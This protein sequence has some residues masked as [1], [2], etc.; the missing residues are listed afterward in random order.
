MEYIAPLPVVYQAP[1]PAVEYITPVPAVVQ[2]P[3]PAVEYIAPA[4]ALFLSPSSVVEFAAPAPALSVAPAPGVESLSHAPVLSRWL[5]PAVDHFSPA[6]A[7]SR[8]ARGRG[9]Q[10]SVSGQ[11]SASRR[12]HAL[13]L[14]SGWRRVEDVSGRVYYWH[15]HTSQTRWT[16]PGSDDDDEDEE[17]E[18]D[19]EEEDEDEED[20]DMDETYAESR[21]PAGF[22]PMR[23]CRWFPSG[24]CGQGWGCMF[25]HS[26]SELHPQARGQGP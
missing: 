13:P 19:E 10:G 5:A 2:A 6:P 25:A 9:L 22:R 14:P 7:V 4:P 15:V 1:T 11:S 8:A 16:P 3:T 23:M 24:N 26:V 21:F 12:R 17:D 20:E 18:G